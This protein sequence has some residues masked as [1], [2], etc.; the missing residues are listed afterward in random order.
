MAE[1]WDQGGSGDP[2]TDIREFVESQRQLGMHPTAI[3]DMQALLLLQLASK[4]G[5]TLPPGSEEFLVA[6]LSRRQ[7]DH[8]GYHEASRLLQ[9]IRM[10]HLAK[11]FTRRDVDEARTHFVVGDRLL[12]QLR[13]GDA[14]AAELVKGIDLARPATPRNRAERRAEKRRKR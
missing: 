4:A 5:L 9:E 10:N 1:G 14:D 2:L 13:A 7:S 3:T 12:Q 8:A 6:F 11:E